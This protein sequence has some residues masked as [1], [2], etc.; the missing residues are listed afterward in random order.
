VAIV[1]HGTSVAKVAGL[2]AG[3]PD[4]FGGLYVTESAELAQR[5]ADAQA[6]REVSTTVRLVA[7]SAVVEMETAETISWRRRG[8]DHTSLDVCEACINTWTVRRVTV[9]ADAYRLAH[10]V[11]RIEGRQVN[12][13]T[14]LREQFG[15][16]LTIVEVA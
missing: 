15:E 9:Y 3:K 6:S 13:Y 4:R 12:P 7:G 2:L 5:Y 8:A 10:S 16:H 11:A 14:W 1:Y